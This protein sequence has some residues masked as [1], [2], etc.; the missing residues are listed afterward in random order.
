MQID[1]ERRRSAGR[2]EQQRRAVLRH[3]G[4]GIF[5]K[6]G[7]NRSDRKHVGQI[8]RVQHDP[9]DVRVPVARKRPAPGL[10]CIDRFDPAGEAEVLNRLHHRARVLIEPVGIFIEA[11]DVGRVLRELDIAGCSDAHGFFRI[12]GHLLRVNV[13]CARLRFEDLI[14]PSAN[15][16]APLLSVHVEHASRFLGIDQDRACVPAVFNRQGCPTRAECP[17]NS[18]SGI[19]RWR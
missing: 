5:A 15:L 6:A 3:H 13:D 2:R 9:P 8:Q 17:A 1:A 4:R 12:G 7:P 16:R 19:R 10:D 18:S 11:D 14:L